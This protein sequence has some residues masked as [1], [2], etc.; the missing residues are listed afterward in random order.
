MNGTHGYP[1][2]C[3]N[4]SQIQELLDATQVKKETKLNLK[5]ICREVIRTHLKRM[6]CL[7]LFAMIPMLS[8]RSHLCD[9]LMYGDDVFH[10]DDDDDSYEDNDGDDDDETNVDYIY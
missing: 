5:H 8:L 9:Y 3:R 7:N 6:D 2:P 10:G 1:P 4:R